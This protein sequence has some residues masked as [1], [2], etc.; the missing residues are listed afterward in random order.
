[1]APENVTKDYET[2]REDIKKLRS[3][4]SALADALVISGKQ[5]AQATKESAVDEARRRLEQISSQTHAVCD[6][7]REAVE[8][9]ERQVAEH[10]CKSLTI[11]FGTG[12]LVGMVLTWILGRR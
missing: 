2:L 12:L 4:L 7:G 11:V 10:L 3:D 1:M 9:V 6:R 5:R 8:T